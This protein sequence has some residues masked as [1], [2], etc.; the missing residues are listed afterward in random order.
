MKIDVSSSETLKNVTAEYLKNIP[1]PKE[2]TEARL[3]KDKQLRQKF[4]RISVRTRIWD[5]TRF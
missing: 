3:L 1:G 4:L 2:W 5:T